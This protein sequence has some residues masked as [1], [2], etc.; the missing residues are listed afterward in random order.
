MFHVLGNR[1]GK[2]DCRVVVSKI[3]AA[4][5]EHRVLFAL[6]I[7]KEAHGPPSDGFAVS[8][9]ATQELRIA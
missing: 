4:I 7:E 1:F 3:L 5:I 2:I 9:L 6:Q 8:R